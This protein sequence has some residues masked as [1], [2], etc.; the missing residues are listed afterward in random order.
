MNN[1]EQLT[2]AGWQ[3]T[4]PGKWRS[5]LTRNVYPEA[6]ALALAAIPSNSPKLYAARRQHAQKPQHHHRRP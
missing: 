1:A 3:Q 6:A 4:E 5:P 2:A